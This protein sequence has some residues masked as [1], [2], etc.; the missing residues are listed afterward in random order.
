[1]L[2]PVGTDGQPLHELSASERERIGAFFAKY[3]EHE[4]GA[5]SKVPGWGTAAEA[6]SLVERTHAFFL[7]CRERSDRPCLIMR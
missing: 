2:S 1:M 6:T 4:V 5:Y 7:V 3:K